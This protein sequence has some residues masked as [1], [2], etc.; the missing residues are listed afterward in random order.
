[1]CLLVHGNRVT[2]PAVRHFGGRQTRES[3]A[4]GG[5]LMRVTLYPYREEG[6]RYGEIYIQM[7]IEKVRVTRRCKLLVRVA[8]SAQ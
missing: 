5:K 7:R 8:T 6:W 3:H 1:M 4:F 2:E